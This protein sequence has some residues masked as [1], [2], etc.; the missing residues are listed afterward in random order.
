MFKTSCSIIISAPLPFVYQ[1]ALTYPAFCSLYRPGSCILRQDEKTVEVQ[2]NSTFLGKPLTWYGYG[3]KTKNRKIEYTQVSGLL[4]GLKA[5][6]LFEQ[7]MDKTKVSTMVTFQKGPWPLSFF[8]ER[9]FGKLG[10]EPTIAQNL[11]DLK[12]E[13]LRLLPSNLIPVA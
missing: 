1:T 10:V 2:I 5:V 4:K 9:F 8:L 7:A 11:N 3:V 13:V 6:W 12:A